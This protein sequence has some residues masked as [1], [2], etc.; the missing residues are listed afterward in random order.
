MIHWIPE[1]VIRL[2][3]DDQI[4][5]HGG[6]YGVLSEN[7]LL[8]TMEKPKN[9]LNYGENVTIYDLAASYGYGFVKNHCFVDGNK[10]IALVAINIFLLING[11]SLVAPEAEAAA[12]ILA[13]AAST[14]TQDKAIYK[15]SQWI[16]KNCIKM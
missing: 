3:H 16:M 10:R 9:L 8:S 13:I 11:F 4:K 1:S 5:E 2:A 7:A 14:E 15:I 12:F 6:S